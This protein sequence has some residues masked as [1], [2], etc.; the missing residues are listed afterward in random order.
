MIQLPHDTLRTTL[1]QLNQQIALPRFRQLGAA[2]VEEKSP[3]ELVTVVDRELEQALTPL[4]CSL[5]SGSRVV[6][7]EAVA[8]ESSLLRGLDQGWVWLLDPLDGTANFAA[9]KPDFATMVALLRDG[10]TVAS[11]IYAPVAD[12]F[13]QAEL[14]AGAWLDGVRWQAPAAAHAPRHGVLKTRF[15]PADY[16]QALQ[17]RLS[18]AEHSAGIG[19]AGSE[20][21]ALSRGEWDFILYWRTLPW[22]HAPGA[23]FL[24][25]SGGRAARLDGSP[26]RAADAGSGLLAVADAAQWAAARALLPD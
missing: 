5:L 1:R 25:E 4:L 17:A 26:Y 21:P 2:D 18:L 20:Y 6:G 23:L 22:D 14:G 8:A 24:H 12:T 7:E 16:Q 19:P 3:G 9:G 10:E 13:A 15:M 11:W